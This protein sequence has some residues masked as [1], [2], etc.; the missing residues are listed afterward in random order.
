MRKLDKF[1]DYIKKGIVRKV[2][3]NKLRAQAL[4]I[5]TKDSYDSLKEIKEKIGINEKNANHV[6]K[7]CYDIIMELIKAK[8]FLK[9]YN[10]EGQGAHEAEVSYLRELNFP[11]DQVQFLNQLRYFRNGIT[12]YGKRFDAVYAKKVFRFMEIIKTRLL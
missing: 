5:E 2:S 10:S 1:E 9:G 12:Y 4:E 8:M 7:N 11:E 6:I 3:P